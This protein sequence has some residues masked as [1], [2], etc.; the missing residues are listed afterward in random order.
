MPRS[1]AHRSH[2]PLSGTGIGSSVMPAGCGEIETAAFSNISSF[3]I[4]DFLFRFG[5]FDHESFAE[6]PRT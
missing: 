5:A 2:L 3:A 6:A 4:H 1:D